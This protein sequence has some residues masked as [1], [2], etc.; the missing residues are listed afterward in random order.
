M[1]TTREPPPK[2]RF[3][4][5]RSGNPMG[6]PKGS[7]NR[8]T[9]VEQLANE[10]VSVTHLGNVR[11][12]SVLDLLFSLIRTKT[13]QGDIRAMRIY[14]VWCKPTLDRTENARVII[15]G[16]P[17]NNRGYERLYSEHWEQPNGKCIDCDLSQDTAQLLY[18][19]CVKGRN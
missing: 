6:R 5:G 10:S 12:Q 8:K 15:L 9:I 16:W 18:E 3:Q 1:K 19:R 17:G 14:E 11:P 13:A 7:K 2:T 4:K